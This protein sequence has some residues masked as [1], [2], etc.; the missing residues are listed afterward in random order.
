W[1]EEYDTRIVANRM[2]VALASLRR[3]M[4]PA[5]IPFGTVLDVSN[6]GCICLREETV[7][8]DVAA[9]E[10]AFKAGK[11]EEAAHLLKGTLLPGYYEEW[12][13]LERD[14]FDT[15]AEELAPFLA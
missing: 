10:Q 14:R 13:L 7:W 9:F 5:G 6:T 2:R 11:K 15:L 1:P 3:Q 8:C 4:E 12:V